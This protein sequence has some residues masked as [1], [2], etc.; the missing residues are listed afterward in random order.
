MRHYDDGQIM[1]FNLLPQP[2]KINT[3]SFSGN[4]IRNRNFIIPGYK[5]GNYEPY[6]INT[7]ISGIQD[8]QI[9]VEKK[10]KLRR[11]LLDQIQGVEQ[12]LHF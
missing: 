9:L 6:V 11:E 3:I 4:F 7:N 10:R 2:L 12:E 1:L 8:N 5:K